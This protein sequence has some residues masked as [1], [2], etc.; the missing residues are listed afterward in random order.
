LEEAAAETTTEVSL[1]GEVKKRPA[2]DGEVKKQP[3]ALADG[4]AKKR[5]A[6][7]PAAPTSFIGYDP[8][9]QL[10]F[11]TLPGGRKPIKEWAVSWKLPTEKPDDDDAMLAVFGDESTREVHAYTV[12]DF[13]AHAAV[14]GQTKKGSLWSGTAPGGEG[15]TLAHRS[16]R[17]PLLSL[18]QG[19]KQILQIRLDALSKI[20]LA[21]EKFDTEAALIALMV[22]IAEK[23][24]MK[25]L[26]R[27][28]LEGTRN[29]ALKA[30]GHSKRKTVNK[31]PAAAI[32]ASA[33]TSVG[34]DA[35]ST[36]AKIPKKAAAK[37]SPKAAAKP[38]A[39]PQIEKKVAAKSSSP[40]AAAKSS[41]KIEKKVA[42]KSSP[43]IV[44]KAAAKSSPLIQKPAPC[45]SMGPPPC[46]V[47]DMEQR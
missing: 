13:K 20:E 2:A 41:P 31:R 47:F 19:G 22:S 18:K 14:K 45:F 6:A 35:S 24:A 39:K 33:N 34:P 16:D 3:G 17:H 40:K 29:E 5:P 11:R 38:A 8:D 4:D 43:K 36:E 1:D 28:E 44:D 37:S 23:Y 12:A 15:L 26:L 10:A 30:L 9:R 46:S 27:T 25:Q 42:A 21:D 7:A 32:E